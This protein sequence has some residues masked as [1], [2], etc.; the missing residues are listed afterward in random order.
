MT[1]LPTRAAF[2]TLFSDALPSELWAAVQGLLGKNGELT[3]ENEKLKARVRNARTAGSW[4][5]RLARK[6]RMGFSVCFA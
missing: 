6:F 1:H 3:A 2:S 5:N 4:R